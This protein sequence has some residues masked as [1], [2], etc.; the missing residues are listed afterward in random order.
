MAKRVKYRIGDVF[1]IPLDD[2]VKGYGRIIKVD[3]PLIFIELYNEKRLEDLNNVEK[4]NN[5]EVI[6]SIWCVDGGIKKGNWVIIGNIPI[7]SNYK[8][9]NFWTK[10][11]ATGNILL[12]KASDT[13]DTLKDALIINEDE[14]QDAQ[15]YGL[16]GDSAVQIA[17]SRELA[18]K[19]K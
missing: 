11:D 3:K 13:F 10:S 8:M 12:Y 17:Y 2:G 9:P 5:C 14:I 4:L 7:D 1:S 18:K 16:Y 6:L 19:T 15:P